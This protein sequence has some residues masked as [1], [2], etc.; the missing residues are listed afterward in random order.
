M[1]LAEVG[2]KSNDPR[3]A[4]VAKKLVEYYQKRRDESI[5]W[6]KHQDVYGFGY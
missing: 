2:A 5:E 6:E 1:E 4:S 3:I